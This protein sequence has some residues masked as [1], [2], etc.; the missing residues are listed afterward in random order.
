M[1]GRNTMG[2]ITDLS[3]FTYYNCSV[4]A[5]TEFGGPQSTSI[6]VRTAEAGSYRVWFDD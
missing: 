5:V 4:Y 6:S 1:T 2:V 3:S